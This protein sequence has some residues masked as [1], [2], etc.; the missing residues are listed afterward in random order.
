[1]LRTPPSARRREAHIDRWRRPTLSCVE[2]HGRGSPIAGI[3]P[4][5]PPPLP[6]SLTR[7]SVPATRSPAPRF[8]RRAR[9]SDATRRGT[10]ILSCQL[11]TNT[12]TILP[13]PHFAAGSARPQVE[14]RECTQAC[15]IRD[16]RRLNRPGGSVPPCHP[17]L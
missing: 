2:G 9:N 13:Q 5:P 14:G 16:Q 8:S 10:R 12:G 11:A 17:V 4:P 6:H 7:S 3:A 1:M 15:S